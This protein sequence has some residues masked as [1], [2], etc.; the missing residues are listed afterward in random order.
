MLVKIDKIMLI[1]RPNELN[2]TELAAYNAWLLHLQ[3]YNEYKEKIADMRADV[4]SIS[5][6]LAGI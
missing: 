5:K 6:A 4:H 3:Q 2:E 1:F